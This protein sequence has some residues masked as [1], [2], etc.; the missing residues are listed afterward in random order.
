MSARRLVTGQPPTRTPIML[1]HQVSGTFLQSQNQST[2]T[3]N[4]EVQNE[5][6][7]PLPSDKTPQWQLYRL[8][9]RDGGSV[10]LIEHQVNDHCLTLRPGSGAGSIPTLS[11]ILTSR[12]GRTGSPL[13]HWRFV[14]VP[15]TDATYWGI[16]PRDYPGYALGTYNNAVLDDQWVVP[17]PTWGGPPTLFH[18]WSAIPTDIPEDDDFEDDARFVDEEADNPDAG[19]PIQTRQA[20]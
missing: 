13:Q 15:G 14:P 19:V 17:T 1:V 20:M 3:L 5:N 9:L 6:H 10:Y 4:D 18:A 12:E 11:P 7:W 8:E 16:V 2:N